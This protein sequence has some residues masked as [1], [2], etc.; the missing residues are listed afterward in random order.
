[1]RSDLDAFLDDGPPHGLGVDNVRGLSLGAKVLL[2]S[3]ILLFF[4][5][6]LT[7]QNLEI[8]YGRTGTG[9]QMLDAFDV[10]GLVI[11]LLT[12]GL[13]TF[14]VIIKLYDADLAPTAAELATFVIA[15]AIF[16]LVVVKNLTDRNSTWASYLAIVLAAAVVAGAALDWA[17]DAISRRAVPGRKRRRLRSIV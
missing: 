10:F 13:L 5:L 11:G 1:M 17:G 3:G 14:V 8:A 4:S 6:F 16:G 7:W 12:V 9:T 2:A 15:A